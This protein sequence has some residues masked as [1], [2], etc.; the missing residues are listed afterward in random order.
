MLAK[1][2]LAPRFISGLPHSSLLTGFQPPVSFS[3]LKA[4]VWLEQRGM[5]VEEKTEGVQRIYEVSLV[6]NTQQVPQMCSLD[7]RKT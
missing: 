4:R 6:P 7:V 5:A 2:P 1:G 3:V